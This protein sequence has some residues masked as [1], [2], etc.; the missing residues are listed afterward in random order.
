MITKKEKR[1]LNSTE[2]IPK[3]R[4]TLFSYLVAIPGF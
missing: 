4:N 1:L 2:L 3:L